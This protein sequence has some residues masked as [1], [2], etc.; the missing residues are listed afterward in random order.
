AI[1]AKDIVEIA[2]KVSPQHLSY[3]ASK[4]VYDYAAHNKSFENSR[5][6]YLTGLKKEVVDVL[7]FDPTKITLA[8]FEQAMDVATLIYDDPTL[9]Q[10]IGE[11]TKDYVAAQHS[12]EW[13]EMAGGGVFEIILTIVLAAV[14]GG[15]GATVA[16]AKN[17]RL[18]T[19]F[20]KVGELMLKFAEA[21]KSRLKALKKYSA[22]AEK[23]DYKDIP[24]SNSTPD[25]PTSDPSKQ[26]REERIA[27]QKQA[28]AEKNKPKESDNATDATGTN[29]DGE[30]TQ[31]NSNACEGGEPINLKTGEERL[32]LVD[33]TLEGPLPLT[34]ARTYRSG[35]PQDS[36]LGFGWS[37][38]LAEKIVWKDDDQPLQFHDGE[39][40]IIEFP[41]PG[42][43]N[44]SHNVVEGLTLIRVNDRHWVITPYGA[45]DGIQKHFESHTPFS[46]EFSLTEIND[47]YK[48]RH[49]FRYRED[50]QHGKRLSVIQS[51]LGDTLHLI[52]SSC[53]RIEKVIR[54]TADG[55]Q[56][57]LVQYQYNEHGDLICATDASG[58][59][60]HYEYHQHIITQRTLK[61][62]YH[63]YFEWDKTGP[64]AKCTRQWGDDI[65][66]VP[67]YHY[68]FA[69]DDDGKGV[70]VT[71]TRGG[72]ETYRFNDRALPVYHK[73]PMG[74]ETH[75]H[76]NALGQ[77]LQTDLPAHHNERR[78]EQFEY[79]KQGRLSKKIDVA[80]NEHTIAYNASG[81]PS[82]ITNP[83]GH[84]WERR[85]N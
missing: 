15:V 17:L 26:G 51:S 78:T 41:I 8:Q 45:P 16:M 28:E 1:W 72:E 9:R 79:D 82:K 38:P 74:A 80:G 43:S 69:W 73:D 75:Y 58:N 84:T 25:T 35:N 32:T 61:T 44:Q 21:Q 55:Q 23:A 30:P 83:D 85:Y 22:K 50:E 13:T 14:T 53:G 71:D 65:H 70:T 36:T 68:Q 27:N 33:A 66:G 19:H 48:N 62:G 6:D 67:T 49:V 18:L 52:P 34:L 64:G 3:V 76:Y 59:S 29:A 46:A 10:M 5:D 57:T 24:T 31:C 77:L 37:H 40:R 20:K 12:L 81:L 60:E 39:G 56:S 4:S 11:F 42:A 2:Q 63:F 7:G 54:K 47:D